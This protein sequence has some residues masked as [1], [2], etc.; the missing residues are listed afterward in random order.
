[1]TKEYH[2]HNDLIKC[3]NV[4]YSNPR[5]AAAMLKVATNSVYQARKRGTLDTLGT[6]SGP[7]RDSKPKTLGSKKIRRKAAPKAVE[8]VAN[9]PAVIGSTVRKAKP[10]SLCG[11][12]SDVSI[13]YAIPLDEGGFD[14]SWNWHILCGKCRQSRTDMHH[15]Q[16]WRATVGRANRLG[17]QMP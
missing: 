8:A 10:C 13:T 15:Y 12:M 6:G 2:K 5:V 9:T 16:M 11:T 1:M 14:S 7:K 4:T 17:R 3:G